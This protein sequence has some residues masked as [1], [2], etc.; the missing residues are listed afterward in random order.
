MKVLHKTVAGFFCAGL[1]LLVCV[2]PA[3][4]LIIDNNGAS[5]NESAPING[6]PWYNVGT[7]NG[8]S[9]VYLKNGWVISAKHVV[10]NATQASVTFGSTTYTSIGSIITLTNP[11]GT[12]A[13]QPT[14]IVLFNIGSTVPTNA[15]SLGIAASRPGTST[16]LTLIG[17]GLHGSGTVTTISYTGGSSLGYYSDGV[18]AKAWGNNTNGLTGTDISVQSRDGGG[19]LLNGFQAFYT[20]FS[21]TGSSDTAQAAVGDSGG[22]VFVKTSGVWYLAGTINA[23]SSAQP[24]Q[25]ANTALNG[26]L[27]AVADLAVY[28][29]QINPIIAAGLSTSVETSDAPLLSPP[30]TALLALLFMGLAFRRLSALK[31]CA[32]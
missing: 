23:V 10:G 14:D 20:V 18:N 3:A 11:S 6:A 21:T 26:D 7:I 25:P 12:Y 16:A 29:S 27:T 8:A 19:N 28:A 32:G 5:K 2:P 13:G 24:G 30:L 15:V 17:Y 1:V 31:R 22:G 9:A 4:A